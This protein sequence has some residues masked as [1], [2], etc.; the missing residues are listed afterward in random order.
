MRKKERV[1]GELTSNNGDDEV[2]IIILIIII[3]APFYLTSPAS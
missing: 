1:V 2:I 3:Y